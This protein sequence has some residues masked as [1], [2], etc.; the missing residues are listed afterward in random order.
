VDILDRLT[1]FD[2]EAIGLARQPI[3]A[4][5]CQAAVSCATEKHL[6]NLQAPHFVEIM[7]HIDFAL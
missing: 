5:G 7:G 2:R 3:A 4:T 6:F 1:R